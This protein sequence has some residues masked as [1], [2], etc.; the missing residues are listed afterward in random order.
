M[1]QA[2]HE[3]LK[4]AKN[5]MSSLERFRCVIGFLV[6]ACLLSGVVFLFVSVV[7]MR[8]RLR[9]LEHN[10]DQ[11]SEELKVLKSHHPDHHN[12]GFD[13]NEGKIKRRKRTI[14]IENLTVFQR[15]SHRVGVLESTTT[16]G[17][18]NRLQGLARRVG[19][20]ESDG[21]EAITSF[22]KLAGR[23]GMLEGRYDEIL[24]GV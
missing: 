5:Q 13:T 20:L 10:L 11:I 21:K 7:S 6:I 2:S 15:L 12:R 22:Q 24:L 23:V 4:Q 17:L 19:V 1:E 18:S 8:T 14:K 9:V 3:K 16:A